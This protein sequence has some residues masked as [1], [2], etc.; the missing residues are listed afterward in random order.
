MSDLEFE[1]RLDRMFA[2]PPHFQDAELFAR[3]VE[4]RLERGWSVR[5]LLIGAAGTVAGLIGVSQIMG[6]GLFL[7]AA[8]D[9]AGEQVQALEGA[10][11][12]LTSAASTN[13]TLGALPVSGEVL[14]MTA[15]LGVMALAFAITR[16]TQEL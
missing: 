14:W 2:E 8:G 7:R 13:A 9:R 12:S 5:R 10:W 6:A 1:T 11:A 16:V 15:A 3:Q 4:T